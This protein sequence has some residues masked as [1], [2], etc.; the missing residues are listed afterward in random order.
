[1]ATGIPRDIFPGLDA[2]L[3]PISGP[4]AGTVEGQ[5]L[6]GRTIDVTIK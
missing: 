3:P 4:P 5:I 1:L 6:K 2:S